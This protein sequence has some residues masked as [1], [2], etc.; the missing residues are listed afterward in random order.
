V[1]NSSAR[2]HTCTR[3]P[4]IACNQASSSSVIKRQSCQSSACDRMCQIAIHGQS[5]NQS[6]SE[7]I[8]VH[9]SQSDPIRANQ[10]V[11][12]LTS[13]MAIKHAHAV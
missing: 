6:P 8:R 7:P 12:D 2:M 5:A 1:W 10:G 11:G 3:A 9:Q 4:A 13:S